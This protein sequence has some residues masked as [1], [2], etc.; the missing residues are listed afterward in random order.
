M[1]NATR[2][3]PSRSIAS[4]YRGGL[5]YILIAS[6]VF[7]AVSFASVT[8]VQAQ[9]SPSVN[10]DLSTTCG[11]DVIMVIDESGSLQPHSELVRSSVRGLLE[12]LVGTGSRL[13]LVEFNLNARTPL[14]PGFIEL[15]NDSNGPLSPTG[16]LTLY[17]DNNYVPTGFTN[18]DAAFLKVAE[19]NQNQ[20]VAPLVI[21]F[22]D[23]TPTIYTNQFG[24]E[25]GGDET[26]AL[27]EAVQSANQVK[28][29]GSH[30]FVVGVGDVSL[31]NRLIAI[32]GP[33]R[34]P[35]ANVPFAQSDYTLTNYDQL[36]AALRQIAFS[37]CGPSV[38]ITKYANGENG[39]QLVGGQTFTGQVVA[40][41]AGQ[42][43]DAFAWTQP[44]SG[45]ATQLGTSQPATTAANGTAQWQWT[46]GTL[47]SPQPW[48]SQFVLTETNLPGYFFESALC[49]RKTIHADSGFVTT[50]FTLTSLPAIFIVGPSDLITC[51]VYNDRLSL[52]VTKRANPTVVPEAGGDV[53]F[54]F[55]ITNHGTA[56]ATLTELTDS[57]F[58]N[59]HGR[60][61]CV[62]DGSV[63]LA[64]GGHYQCSIAARIAGN[65]G[66][67]HINTVTATIRA[68]NG[69]TVTNR[70]SATVTFRDSAPSVTID[71]SVSP[72]ALPEPGGSFTSQITITN[73]SAGEPL[74]LTALTDTPFG[75]ITSVGGAITATSCVVPQQ[76]GRSGQANAAYHCQ[77]TATVTGVPG[78]YTDSLVVVTS[79]D[80]GTVMPF[81][82]GQ[83][84]GVLNRLPDATLQAALTPSAMVEPGGAVI[85]TAI[86]TN[87]SNVEPLTF[88][89]LTTT[90]GDLAEAQSLRTDCQVPQTLEPGANYQC[91]CEATVL[92][93]SGTYTVGLNALVA[94][95]EGSNLPLQRVTELDI[96]DL[97][98][99]ILVTKQ[100]NQTT[101]AEPGGEITFTI[102]VKNTSLV[103]DVEITAVVD[104]I[105]GDLT[106]SCVPALP[107]TLT[108]AATIG[109]HV[110]GVVS[111]TVGTIHTN[112][113]SAY[114]IDDDGSVVSDSDQESVEI[115]DVPSLL[116]I[117]QVAE[118]ANLP[119]PG[120][121]VTIT[122]IIKN[123]SPT[124]DVIIS[125]V[126]TN[127]VNLVATPSARTATALA[128][129]LIDIGATCQPSLPA[130]L[131]PGETLQCTFAKIVT[132][133]I[134]RRHISDVVVSGEDDESLPLMQTSREAID[135]IDVPSSI[136]VT[137]SS[138]P[139]SVP[140]AGAL[141]TFT[142]R[143]KNTS[144]VDTV[145]IETLTSSR[146]GD[147]GNYCTALLPALL[148]PGES[149]T[150]IFREF[151]SGDVDTLL[152]Q[153]VYATAIDDDG[154]SLDDETQSAIGVT[155][156]PSSIR[157]VQL[158]DPSGVAEPGELVTFTV[159]I[160]NT[161]PVD[162]V[163]VTAI[164]EN[165]RGDISASCEPTLP[166]DLLPTEELRCHFSEFVGGNAATVNER[167]VTV[168]AIDDDA[169]VISD[170]D[171]LAVDV[172]DVPPIVAL[173]AEALPNQLLETGEVVTVS[174]VLVNNGPEIITV[175]AM[176]STI[177]G[178]LN[179]L[180][181]CALPQSLAANG[182]LYGCTYSH[183]VEGLATAPPINDVTALVA[184][185]D[186]NERILL[187][188]ADLFLI[189]VEP[190][191]QLNKDDA[192]LVD[193]FDTP[194]DEGKIT[195]GDTLRYTI[196]VTNTGNGP[197][198]QVLLEDTPD[199]NTALI[200][201][202]VTTTKG[203]ILLGNG[204]GDTRVAVL[205]GD[206]AIG[207]SA[208][209]G[210]DV[211]IREGTGTTLLRNQAFLSYGSFNEPSGFNLEGSDDPNTPFL[212]DPTDTRVILPPTSLDP[213]EEPSAF[214]RSIYLPMIQR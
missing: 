194:E 41:S 28:A 138:N 162:T 210:L 134:Q 178:D 197:A 94:D 157:V 36:A 137:E 175:S 25:V 52:L 176:S 32:S 118:P 13:A 179:G 155:D 5:L 24:A 61:D 202:S 74:Q 172:L 37:L 69:T 67:P 123:I 85:L 39:P 104:D 72:S 199:P 211:L 105:Y 213:E 91:T 54:T 163:T 141:V 44:V 169:V 55:D 98:S 206:L 70:A 79:D 19:L 18:W 4:F 114:G 2:L 182:G 159:A 154:E 14:G 116:E 92:Q 195:P 9:S 148:L 43:T 111:G 121:P 166:V 95:D 3:T 190:V 59:L 65:V 73:N 17:L 66:T 97:P 196:Q 31:E 173:T 131:A 170:F 184:D 81:T 48:D 192:L 50:P 23:D 186:G 33:D 191:L 153:Q 30:I 142:V 212:G 77:F 108:P 125:K 26:R 20:S 101:I 126:E 110:V 203:T 60:G 158:A 204:T 21:F 88:T 149:I 113:V 130:R 64:V 145:T 208:V 183:Y 93:N 185:D 132:G 165:S 96:T 164:D 135:I 12:A 147:L 177:A 40:S 129:A 57:A 109:C 107:A 161:S 87:N 53:T 42:P 58:G 106:S 49:T 139:V 1:N 167:T 201:G 45:P 7:F 46:P 127:E 103:D 29:Q 214:G 90:L 8:A 84:V 34:F 117:T 89:T 143:A 102:S 136:R 187:D 168:T 75:D 100:A 56:P 82:R 180:G 189:A 35:D 10:P 144:L 86:V 83:N 207:E 122:T 140:E 160:R 11:L 51:D 47:Q 156:T 78:T 68:A 115:T 16:D 80:D 63:S 188:E 128:A 133:P 62:A 146:F 171:L 99:S 6:V 15:S 198:Q 200:A 151:V 71:R 119:E 124:D 22:T 120:G 150:C 76:L 193:L 209:I 38:T 181:E 152:Q 205:L 27:N 174:L 112:V